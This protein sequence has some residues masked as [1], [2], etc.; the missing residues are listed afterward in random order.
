LGDAKA[1]LKKA[2]EW[3][4]PFSGKEEALKILATL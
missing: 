3:G 4:E 2:T 1:H